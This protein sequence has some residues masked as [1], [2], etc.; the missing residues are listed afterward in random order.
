MG[1]CINH[2]TLERLGAGADNRDEFH[3]VK[4]MLFIA[5][6]PSLLL[7]I[8]NQREQNYAH[9]YVHF[10]ASVRA[11]VEHSFWEIKRHFGYTNVRY[12]SLAKITAQALTLFTPFNLWMVRRQFLSL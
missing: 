5:D 1:N 7:A 11:E 9:R 3:D 12:R 8:K 6:K 10:K 4:T 2:L